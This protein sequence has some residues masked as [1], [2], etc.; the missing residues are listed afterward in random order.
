MTDG[1]TKEIVEQLLE[2]PLLE[3]RRCP[4]CGR[5]A[6]LSDTSENY[7]CLCGERFSD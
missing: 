5:F 3:L 4:K 2:R 1:P 7:E 6:P